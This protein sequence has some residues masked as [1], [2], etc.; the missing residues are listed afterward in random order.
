MGPS[1]SIESTVCLMN[2]R[3]EQYSEVQ[4]GGSLDWMS[5]TGF[6]LALPLMCLDLIGVL[7]MLI[8]MLDNL[9]LAENFTLFMSFSAFSTGLLSDLL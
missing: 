8:G 1:S 6:N 3:T 7:F 9:A 5:A 2:F 4:A